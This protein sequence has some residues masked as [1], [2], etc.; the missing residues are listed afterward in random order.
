MRAKVDADH[1]SDTVSRRSRTGFLVWLNSA[2]VH[3]YSKKQ[4]SVESSS[5]GSEFVA[6]KQ[7]CEYIIGLRYKLR[8]MGIPC[9]GPTYIEGDN[10]SVLAN[11]TIPDSKLRKKNQS[12]CYH[13]VREGSARDVWRTG[14]IKS[15]LNEA[16]LLTKVLPFGE[17]RKRFVRNL[18]HHIFRSYHNEPGGVE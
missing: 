1:A 7:C 12:I 9:V 14:Y 6:L 8:M 5:H 18:L 4:G 17:K 11:S 16:D 10:Q 13:M 15:E 3:W 2:L